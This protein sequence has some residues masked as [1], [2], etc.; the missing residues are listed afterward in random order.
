MVLEDSANTENYE[1]EEIAKCLC[2]F[3]EI[4]SWVAVAFRKMWYTGEVKSVG[5]VK[6]RNFVYGEDW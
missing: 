2:C 5:D 6:N 4:N 1:I 3:Y